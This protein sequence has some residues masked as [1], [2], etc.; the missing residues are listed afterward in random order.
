MDEAKAAIENRSIDMSDALDALH[1]ANAAYEGTLL[2]ETEVQRA[3]SSCL[4]EV[5][6]A[7]ENFDKAVEEIRKNGLLNSAWKRNGDRYG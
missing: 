2:R 4:C 1:L 5:N 7:Q 3:L 6:K